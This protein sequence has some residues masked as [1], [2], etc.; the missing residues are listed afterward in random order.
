MIIGKNRRAVIENIKAAAKMQDFYKKVEIDDPVLTTAQAREITD[1]YIASKNKSNFKVKSFFARLIANIG[2][3]IL[4]KNTEIIG[5][6]KLP[7][8]LNGVLIT[9]NHFGPLENTVIR[10]FVKRKGQ[11]KLNVVSQVTNFA[12]SGIIGFLMKYGD[13]IPLSEDFRYLT[14]DFIDVLDQLVKKGETVLIYPEQEMWFNYRKPR[15]L[16][17]GAYHFA[18]KLNAPIISCFVEI[19]DLEQKENEEFYKTKYKL[20]IL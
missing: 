4:N 13:T 5:E 16:K 17:R 12:M 20:H 9:S 6:E 7:K 1:A 3:G 8:S 14:R 11:K 15:P 18:S 19:I 10:H 2:S